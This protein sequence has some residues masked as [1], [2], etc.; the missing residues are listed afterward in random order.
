MWTCHDCKANVNQ[1]KYGFPLLVDKTETYIHVYLCVCV[2]V[3]IW[4]DGEHI[5]IFLST[6]KKLKP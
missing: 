1:R 3:Y 2:C 4:M 6:A 5:S